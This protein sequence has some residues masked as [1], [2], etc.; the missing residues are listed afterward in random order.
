MENKKIKTTYR[1]PQDLR[2]KLLLAVRE[3]YGIKQ[4][5]RWVGEAIQQ[6]L[7]NDIG[8]ASVGLGEV[9]DQQDSSE[10]LLLDE[11]T[12][13]ALETGMTTIRRQDPLYE[14]VQSAVI[15]AAIRNRL[16]TRINRIV[17]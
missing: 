10:V 17:L 8:L 6:L 5:S 4:K 2:E 7:L 9:H 1:L 13:L 16:K 14:G 12:Y 11:A 3:D 15:R